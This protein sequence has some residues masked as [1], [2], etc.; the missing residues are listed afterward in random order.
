MPE[1]FNP[2]N[3]NLVN[4]QSQFVRV[5]ERNKAGRITLY[6]PLQ[7][8][9]LLVNSPIL[10]VGVRS[11]AVAPHWKCGGWASMWIPF[12]PSST[13]EFT[14]A[15]NTP[16]DRTICYL[17]QLNLVKFP[18]LGLNQYIL[19]LSFPYW[20]EDIYI[21][22]WQFSMAIA[23]GYNPPSIESQLEKIVGFLEPNEGVT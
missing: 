2:Q 14:A 9:Q 11:E 16:N 10:L 8:I 3:W 5:L 18:F 15:I 1:L 12:L 23:G 21:E 19:N 20:L 6:H 13:T 22:V 4:K 7:D 17:N